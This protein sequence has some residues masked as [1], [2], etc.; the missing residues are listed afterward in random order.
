[1]HDFQEQCQVHGWCGNL[2]T[3]KRE[4][5]C[6]IRLLNIMRFSLFLLKQCTIKQPDQIAKI[7][8]NKCL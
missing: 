4:R 5:G 8:S 2:R 7:L 3:A 1:M 6:L